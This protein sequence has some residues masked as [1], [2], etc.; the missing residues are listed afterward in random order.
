LILRDLG[1][2]RLRFSLHLFSCTKG[3]VSEQK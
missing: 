2:N 3:I 1:R